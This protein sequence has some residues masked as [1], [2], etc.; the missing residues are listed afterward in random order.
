MVQLPVALPDDAQAYYAKMRI[1]GIGHSQVWAD[2]HMARLGMV[3]R[4]HNRGPLHGIRL[5]ADIYILAMGGELT[6]GLAIV[7]GEVYSYLT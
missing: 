6:G 5:A 2:Y 7:L 4:Q 1:S 3:Y